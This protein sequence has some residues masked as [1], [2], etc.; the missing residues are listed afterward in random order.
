[1][2]RWKIGRRH[3]ACLERIAELHELIADAE[4]QTLAG[5]AVQLRRLDAMLDD[6]DQA[7]IGLLESALEVVE[8]EVLSAGSMAIAD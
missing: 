5:A 6:E 1:M 8:D 2:E 4:A 3:E 7:A